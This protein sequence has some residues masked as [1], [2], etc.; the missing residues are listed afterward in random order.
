MAGIEL[1]ATVRAPEPFEPPE[2]IVEARSVA[3]PEPRQEVEADEAERRKGSSPR[4]NR[5][6]IRVV[7][8]VAQVSPSGSPKTSWDAQ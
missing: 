5:S 7:F 4:P 2:R 3:V 1:P 6:I 8:P